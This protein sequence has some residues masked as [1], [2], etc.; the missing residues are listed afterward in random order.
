MRSMF[1][2]I[3][4]ILEISRSWYYSQMDFSPLLD[5]RF[6]PFAARDEEWIVIGYKRRHPEMGFREIAYAMMDEDIEYLSPSTV[7]RILKKHDLI[8]PW[9]HLT[10]ESTRPERVKHPD[11]EWQTDIM[12]LKIRGRFF[13]LL[14][15][16]DECSRYIVHGEHH[17]KM[18]QYSM[19][20]Y[21]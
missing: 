2:D 1:Y 5:G 8:T 11:V 12:Y 17:F 20:I 13:Y 18:A 16:I 14:I 9:K 15:F 3:L 21:I 7:Y 19:Y 6:N 10:W 4:R